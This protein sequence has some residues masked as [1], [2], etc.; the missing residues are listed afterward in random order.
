[1]FKLP[2]MTSQYGVMLNGK[3][4]AFDYYLGFINGN[5]TT[6]KNILEDN[7]AKEIQARVRWNVNPDLK[8]GAGFDYSRENQQA[9]GLWDHTFEIYSRDTIS[10]RRLGYLLEFDYAVKKW[11]FRGEGIHFFFSDR[12]RFEKRIR[13]FYGGYVET[14]YFLS[15]N[16]KQGFQL[17]GRL[18]RAQFLKTLD[19]FSG[20]KRSDSFI[21][22][23]NWYFN[24][25]LRWQTNVIHDRLDR[26]V[27]ISDSRY[28]GRKDGYQILS[29]LQMKF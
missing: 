7:T 10:G 14:G 5:G 22:G 9:L 4:S 21:I 19:G 27:I 23:Y 18:E 16:A 3:I 26:K 17:I 28:N 29:M 13:Q 20:P 6:S 12:F 8:C 25:L 1:M 15:G 24:E 2:S 11:S